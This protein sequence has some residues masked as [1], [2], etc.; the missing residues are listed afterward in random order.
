MPAGAAFPGTVDVQLNLRLKKSTFDGPLH[1]NFFSGDTRDEFLWPNSRTHIFTDSDASN[2]FASIT[3]AIGALYTV[4]LWLEV[5]GIV[6]IIKFI[7]TYVL[8]PGCWK[9]YRLGMDGVS[10][11]RGRKPV[12]PQVGER[13]QVKGAPQASGT[14]IGHSEA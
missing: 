1:A 9:S 7:W 8:S 12:I 2:V 4:M 6:I 3:N 5:L 14:R 11:A 10:Y 13:I